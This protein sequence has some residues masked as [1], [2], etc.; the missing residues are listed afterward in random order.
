[1]SQQITI[2]L[3]QYTEDSNINLQADKHKQ[4]QILNR[5]LQ[6]GIKQSIHDLFIHYFI[7]HFS[8]C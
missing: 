8:M 5:K 6:P 1:M 3:A 4:M 7:V 2:I